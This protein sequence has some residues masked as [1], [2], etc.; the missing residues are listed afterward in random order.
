VLDDSFVL[1]LN[2]SHEPVR[3]RLPARRF[4]NR[5]RQVLSTADPGAPEDARSWAAWARAHV[6][7]RSVLLMRRAW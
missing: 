7:P 3:F 5:W 1:L 6:E 4:G 2:A